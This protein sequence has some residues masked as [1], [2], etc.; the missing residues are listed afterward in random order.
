[1]ARGSWRSSQA[2]WCNMVLTVPLCRRVFI[3]QGKGRC[4]RRLA[5]FRTHP[6]P[7]RVLIKRLTTLELV[8]TNSPRVLQVEK[9]WTIAVHSV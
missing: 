9:S 7:R 1:V 4:T 8:T 6:F 5:P 3:P 2:P